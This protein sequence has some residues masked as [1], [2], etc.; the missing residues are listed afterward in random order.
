MVQEINREGLAGK[1]QEHELLLVTEMVSQR[2]TNHLL[3][4]FKFSNGSIFHQLPA[5]P[6]PEKGLL[7]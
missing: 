2:H 5:N 6:E 7:N 4:G 3:D 1:Q